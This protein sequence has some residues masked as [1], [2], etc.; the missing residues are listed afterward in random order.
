MRAR[1][2]A[3]EHVCWAVRQGLTPEEVL[4]GFGYKP[5]VPVGW[6][7]CVQLLAMLWERDQACAARRAA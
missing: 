7:R 2:I 5:L 1:A 4:E 3:I 6:P